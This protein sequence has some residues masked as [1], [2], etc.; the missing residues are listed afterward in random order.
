METGLENGQSIGKGWNFRLLWYRNLT[1]SSRLVQC[2]GI[3]NNSQK[4][5]A[6]TCLVWRNCL[7]LEW[8]Q[9]RKLEGSRPIIAQDVNAVQ[10]PDLCVPRKVCAG[11]RGV[12]A[13]RAVVLSSIRWRSG[14]VFV[15]VVFLR[16]KKGRKKLLHYSLF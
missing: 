16:L 10:T 3:Q 15:C 2:H 5:L 4:N 9:N 8:L 13:V 1:M 6:Q 12:L 7:S 14:F 11:N